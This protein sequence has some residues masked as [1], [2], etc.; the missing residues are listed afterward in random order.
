MDDNE[1]LRRVVVHAT[2]GMLQNIDGMGLN[3]ICIKI[4]EHHNAV[5]VNGV[6]MGFEKSPSAL[7][8]AGLASR[9]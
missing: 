8:L 1:M 5:F 7:K 9:Q 4:S 2:G 6:T 3:D